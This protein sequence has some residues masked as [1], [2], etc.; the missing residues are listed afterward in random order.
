MH[1]TDSSN[2]SEL[3][4][5]KAITMEIKLDIVKQVQKRER[6]GN[7]G[8]IVGLSQST[9]TTIIEDKDHIIKHVKGSV[10]I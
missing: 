8:R 4:K 1:K 6:L 2:D 7:I 9:V 5:R 3:K 10:V